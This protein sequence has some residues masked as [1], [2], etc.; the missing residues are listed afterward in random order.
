MN[1]CPPKSPTELYGQVQ[2]RTHIFSIQVQHFSNRYTKQHF[3][4]Y[5]RQ[6]WLSELLS[7]VVSDY[8]NKD[9]KDNPI[10]KQVCRVSVEELPEN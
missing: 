2:E 6:T 4:L 7:T 10:D 8:I 9:W 5:S 3:K 1:L